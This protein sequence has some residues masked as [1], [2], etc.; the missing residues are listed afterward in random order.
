MDVR[1]YIGAIIKKERGK[2]YVNKFVDGNNCKLTLW[3][4]SFELESS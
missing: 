2:P 3:N 1:P 4:P